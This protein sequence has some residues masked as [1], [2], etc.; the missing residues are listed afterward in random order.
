MAARPWQRKTCGACQQ[1]QTGPRLQ[2][3]LEERG[4][5]DQLV[6]QLVV[7]PGQQLDGHAAQDELRG[8]AVDQQLIQ[9]AAHLKEPLGALFLQDEARNFLCA[10]RV[11]QITTL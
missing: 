3:V 7:Q 10:A 8:N 9:L 4:L 11:A 5:L 1:P 2:A 6:L